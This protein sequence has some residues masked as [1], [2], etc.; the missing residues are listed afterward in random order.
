M[1][2]YFTGTGN[3]LS[4]AKR[5]GELLNE[6]VVNV[7][8]FR[9]D[10]EVI[11]RDPVNG[12]V[13]PVYGSDSPRVYKEF[14]L[15]LKVPSDSYC[16]AVGTMNRMDLRSF[17][18]VDQ[19]LVNSGAKLSYA[20]NLLMPGNCLPTEGKDD[21]WRLST[22]AERTKE[23]ADAVKARAVNFQSPGIGTGPDFVDVAFGQNAE[24]K[25]MLQFVIK[26]SCIGCGLCAR[27]CPLQNIRMEN[28]KAV[29]GENCTACYACFHWCPKQATA[30]N[31]VLPALNERGQY[32]HPA[33]TAKTIIEINHS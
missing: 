14:L 24:Q 20:V 12:F 33:A 16:F 15:K 6:N 22:E 17:S 23:V 27:I 21:H 3:S 9:D 11:S 25:S 18:Y 7:M 4:V 19:A 29:H 10:A 5:L 2:Y 1:I 31:S 32:R 28:G 30:F 26:D 13:Y 8:H